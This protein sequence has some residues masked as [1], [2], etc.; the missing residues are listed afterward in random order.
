MSINYVKF[1]DTTFDV[2]E[3]FKGSSQF[4]PAITWFIDI[5]KT[6]FTKELFHPCP[7]D[8]TVK[9]YNLTLDGFSGIMEHLPGTYRTVVRLY[10]A[11][12]DNIL[13]ANHV[14]DVKLTND[15]NNKDITNP[16]KI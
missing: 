3:Y 11:K 15:K 4:N 7:Y 2:C 16:Y 12:D 8:G 14:V 6:S 5:I 9:G 1:F 10:D 13:T